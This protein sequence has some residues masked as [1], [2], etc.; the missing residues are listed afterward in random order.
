VRKKLVILICFMLFITTGCMRNDS[1][2]EAY[3]YTHDGIVR[4]AGSTTVAPLMRELRLAY[5]NKHPGRR[6][7]IQEIGTSAGIRATLEGVSHIAMSSRYLS[8]NEMEQGLMPLPFALDGISVIVHNDNEVNN[9]TSEQVAEI[10]RGNITNWSEVG[11]N[12]AEIIVVS[13]EEGSGIRSTFEELADLEITIE[14]DGRTFRDSEVARGAIFEKGTGAVKGTVRLS[15][16]SIGY[17]TVG[18]LDDTVQSVQ[19]NGISFSEEAV[20]N[21][22]Y[23]FANTFLV[24]VTENIPANAQAFLDFILSEEGQTLVRNAGYVS[25]Y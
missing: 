21:G 18:V 25:I 22:T 10:F 8:E 20:R 9:L 2:L 6:I 16:N 5:E 24:G 15:R 1:N 23:L 4:V 13:R 12:D 19:I 3:A 17:V 14:R 11:G 7:E